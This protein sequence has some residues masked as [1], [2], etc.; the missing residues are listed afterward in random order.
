MGFR[1]G[2]TGS[3][4]VWEK[5]REEMEEDREGAL[6]TRLG[7]LCG[8]GGQEI[9]ND[10]REAVGI[11]IGERSG[12]GEGREQKEGMGR[13]RRPPAGPSH[14]PKHPQFRNRVKSLCCRRHQ[15]S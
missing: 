9:R 12:K 11:G 8:R 3:G 6:G 14:C 1:G 5:I 13:K 10:G 2:D 7:K 4:M 15:R